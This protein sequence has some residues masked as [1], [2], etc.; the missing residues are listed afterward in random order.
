MYSFILIIC[1][2]FLCVM[3]NNVIITGCVLLR[4][5]ALNKYPLLLLLL[6]LLYIYCIFIGFFQ[7]ISLR[8]MLI[9][10]F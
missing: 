1:S 5:I 7:Y 8:I 2:S 9:M 4:E 3:C 6:L 10:V